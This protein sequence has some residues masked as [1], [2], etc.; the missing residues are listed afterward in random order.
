MLAL[1]ASHKAPTPKIQ[2]KKYEEKT[3]AATSWRAAQTGALSNV[4][5][6]YV[7]V[8]EDLPTSMVGQRRLGGVGMLSVSTDGIAVARARGHVSRAVRDQ[9]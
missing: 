8:A 9:V 1:T 3:S 2:K 7:A 4:A 5:R 6:A